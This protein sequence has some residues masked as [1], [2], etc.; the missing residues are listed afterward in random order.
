MKEFL[1]EDRPLFESYT[2]V[3][4]GSVVGWTALTR[5]RVKE[6]VDHTA[7]MSLYVQKAFRRKGIGSTLARTLLNRAIALDLRCIFA[8][9]FKDAASVCSF[10]E[11]R[12]GFSAT[13]VLPEV[14]SYSGKH[15]DILVFEKLRDSLNV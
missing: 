5:Y 7:E 9:V 10:A 11:Q 12:C 14:F 13:G 15:Y 2:C 4:E 6:D 8:M 3:N 1:L